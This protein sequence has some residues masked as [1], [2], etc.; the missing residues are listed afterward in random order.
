M[1]PRGPLPQKPLHNLHAPSAGDDQC[2][3][4]AV[5]DQLSPGESMDPAVLSLY[6]EPTSPFLPGYFA[7]SPSYVVTVHAICYDSYHAAA[8]VCLAGCALPC[9]VREYPIWC[10]VCVSR[11]VLMVLL[12]SLNEECFYTGTDSCLVGVSMNVSCHLFSHC[13]HVCATLSSRSGL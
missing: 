4:N 7:H 11:T 9:L 2:E 12:L 10:E 3:H 13:Q 1:T 6:L 5:G 8:A